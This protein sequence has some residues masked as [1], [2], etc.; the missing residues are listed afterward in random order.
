MRL[1]EL[2]QLGLGFVS[3]RGL[4]PGPRCAYLAPT[5][6]ERTSAQIFGRCPDSGSLQK[7]GATRPGRQHPKLMF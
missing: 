7:H 3:L 5:D 4:A 1:E 6:L 2:N